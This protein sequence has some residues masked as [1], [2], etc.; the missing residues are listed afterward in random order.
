MD[1]G[2]APA[3]GQQQVPAFAE[4]NSNA[5]GNSSALGKKARV[6]KG[7]GKIDGG[8]YADADADGSK[9]RCVST[10]CIGEMW[11]SH[12]ILHLAHA[13]DYLDPQH[14]EGANQSMYTLVC[15]TNVT[16]PTPYPNPMFV[17][18]M[19]TRRPQMR[20]QPASL[21]RLLLRLQH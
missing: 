18:E 11:Q 3:A 14:A 1:S 8:G 15:L 16:F 7:K 20:W 10:A 2:D 5:G 6:R 13:T 9:R 21:R 4:S 12:I 17:A 19:L